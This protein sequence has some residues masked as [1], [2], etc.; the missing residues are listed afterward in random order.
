VNALQEGP[1]L[2]TTAVSR[3]ALPPAPA[4]PYRAIKRGMDITAAIGLLA[5][6]S[7]ILLMAAIAIRLSSPG[8]V[9]FRQR[10]IGRWSEH[11]TILKFRT[12]RTGTP[13]LASHLMGPGSSHVTAVGQWLRRTSIDELP[14]LWNILR[15]EM[16]L[17]GPRPALHN[18]HDL[19]AMRQAEGIDAL[20]PGVSGWAQIHGRDGIPMTE[21][22]A[23]DRWYLDHCS[24][25]IDLWII[26]RTAFTVFSSR[27]VF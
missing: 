25:P 7:P 19:V 14:Q 24:L 2:V 27:G 1:V 10:R 23:R 17:V 8:P 13:D 21:K 9:L 3:R 16:T 20:K 11:F 4:G 6:A 12:M 26:L 15:G 5:L 18:Q 22:V